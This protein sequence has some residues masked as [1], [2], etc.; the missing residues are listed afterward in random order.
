VV[1]IHTDTGRVG[2]LLPASTVPPLLGRY[3]AGGGT[4]IGLLSSPTAVAITHPGTVIVLEAGIPQLAAFDL[5]GNPVRYFGTALP[6]AFTLPLPT[7]ATYL[8]VAVDGSGQIYILFYGIDGHQPSDY[9]IDVYTPNGTPLATNSTGTNVPHLAVDYFRGI[10]AANYTA[11]LGSDGKSWGGGVPRSRRSACQRH[12]LSCSAG[13][14]VLRLS[15]T[16]SG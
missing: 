3:T 12:S 16:L 1:A 13:A 15:R 8:D 10:Y 4:Q 7:P 11:L 9:R 5:N 14:S 2:R 6:A